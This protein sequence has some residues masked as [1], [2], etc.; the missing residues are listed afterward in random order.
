LCGC[1]GEAGDEGD[2]EDGEEYLDEGCG[3]GAGEGGEGE[4][5]R[6]AGG[7]EEFWKAVSGEGA[8]E[9]EAATG[10]EIALRVG[11][12]EGGGAAVRKHQGEQSEANR[13]GG[14]EGR[15]ALAQIPHGRL[16]LVV[17]RITLIR[18]PLAV[19]PPAFGHLLF[20]PAVGRVAFGGENLGWWYPTHLR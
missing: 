17:H 8:V 12:G 11:P 16:G 9:Q 5:E 2:G 18:R 15:N 14:E 1:D 10:E 4:E 19:G 20:S 13:G 3:D 6:V 7:A